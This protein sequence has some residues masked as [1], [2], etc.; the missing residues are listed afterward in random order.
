M[1]TRDN[2]LLARARTFTK[3]FREISW[4]EAEVRI[5]TQDG[6]AIFECDTF[7]WNIC[8]DLDGEENLADNFFDVFPGIPY[9]I[10]WKAQTPPHILHV[11]NSLPRMMQQIPGKPQPWRE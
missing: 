4:P 3:F 11:G 1:L 2:W 9:E 8:L 5:R 6:R 7:A 10:E